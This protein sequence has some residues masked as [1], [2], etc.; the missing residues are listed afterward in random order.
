MIAVCPLDI[1][2]HHIID[3]IGL[4]QLSSAFD[5]HIEMPLLKRTR[6][7]ILE[8]GE[9]PSLSMAMTGLAADH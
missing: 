3:A 9:S 6:M 7:C 4:L 2:W 8:E 1:R 5:G